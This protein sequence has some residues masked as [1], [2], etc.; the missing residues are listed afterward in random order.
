M[1]ETREIAPIQEVGGGHFCETQSFLEKLASRKTVISTIGA[2]A[3]TSLAANAKPASVSR[4]SSLEA[5]HT[6]EVGITTNE[7]WVTNPA[8]AQERAAEVAAIGATAVRIFVPITPGQAD[9]DND[10]T[11]I[12]NAAQAAKDHNLDLTISMLGYL[13]A[14]RKHRTSESNLGYLPTGSSAINKLKTTLGSYMHILSGANTCLVDHNTGAPDPLVR[15]KLEIF[16]EVN[17]KTFTKPQ[18]SNTPK[19]YLQLLQQTYPFIKSESAEITSELKAA[20]QEAEPVNITVVGGAFAS[21]HDPTGFLKSM[22]EAYQAKPTGRIM[23]ALSFHS[24]ATGGKSADEVQ[25]N[26]YD[27]LGETFEKY[28]KYQI[29][30]YNNEFGEQTLPKPSKRYLYNGSPSLNKLFVPESAQSSSTEKVLKTAA[31][32]PGLDMVMTFG[33]RDEENLATGMQTG[34]L[35]P[36]GTKKTSWKSISEAIGQAKTAHSTS[37]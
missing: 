2:L 10:K 24:Y 30:L 22:G 36:D 35:Y 15:Y 11:R 3:F 6:V 28:F 23:D 8:E 31:C 5:P 26:L 20:S 32:L 33:L 1:G 29:P 7:I 37:C 9:I 18:N 27:N 21:A 17:S 19:K 34:V 25:L 12:C 16:N 13:R 4:V 14:N